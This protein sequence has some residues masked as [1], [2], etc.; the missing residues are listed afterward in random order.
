MAFLTFPRMELSLEVR[1]IIAAK[2]AKSATTIQF[3]HSIEF[4]HKQFGVWKRIF[5]Y[6]L[7]F[8]PLWI[9]TLYFLPWKHRQG[10]LYPPINEIGDKENQTCKKYY[11]N[12]ATIHV[13]NSL[14]SVLIKTCKGHDTVVSLSAGNDMRPAETKYFFLEKA[15][16]F[17]PIALRFR[18]K[19][20]T[21]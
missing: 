1:R 11:N 9:L 2:N 20:I 8:N 7:F 12:Q 19:I 5:R 13:N 15:L 21:L 4:Y 10:C 6:R 17:G 18:W 3:L 16:N 14:I